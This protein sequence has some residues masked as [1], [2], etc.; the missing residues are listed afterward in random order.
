MEG[1]NG[2][3]FV[4][5]LHYFPFILLNLSA[6]LRNI[7]R[8]MEESA[9]NLGAHGLRCSAASSSRSPCPATSPARALVF[10]K[11]FDDLAT[12]LLLN[13]N[14]MLAP[15]A[16]L[17]ITSV[18]I[19]DPM[20]YVISVVMIVVAVARRMWVSALVADGR[21]YATHAARRRRARAAHADRRG[22]SVAGLRASCC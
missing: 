1:L 14:D 11:V 22:K 2:V 17:R 13:V 3:I 20:G 12:P 8:A 16:Y 21:D 7:D 6:A 5:A 15:Q 10:V 18:G 19:D 4:E 9:Q